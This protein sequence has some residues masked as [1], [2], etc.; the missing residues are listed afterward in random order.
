MT[1]WPHGPEFNSKFQIYFHNFNKYQW[2]FE[3]HWLILKETLHW[4]LQ[5]RLCRAI[6]GKNERSCTSSLNEWIS[7]VTSATGRSFGGTL[8]DRPLVVLSA[9]DQVSA[10]RRPMNR[11]LWR[12]WWYTQMSR[13]KGGHF[14]EKILFP[15][16]QN[17]NLFDSIQLTTIRAI[18]L[19][20]I[21]FRK[22]KLIIKF[23]TFDS[24]LSVNL[25]I[26]QQF[27]RIVIEFQW[28]NV[29]RGR[30]FVCYL[31]NLMFRGRAT[32]RKMVA[33]H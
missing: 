12:Q 13:L 33:V 30:W 11:N 25:M 9:D 23:S 26:F 31:I 24:P 22:F 6:N 29:F 10:S 14:L 19:F 15:P 27:A 18:G 4:R 32:S 20:L 21:E 16:F 5:Y 8:M 2:N 7:S 28:K 1:K 3:D 17:S